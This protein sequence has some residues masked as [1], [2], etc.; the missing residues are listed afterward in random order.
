[1]SGRLAAALIL[2]LALVLFT[3]CGE[4]EQTTIRHERFNEEPSQPEPI[5][6]S[7][8]SLSG[9]YVITSITDEYAPANRTSGPQ[10]TI[11][12]DAAGQFVREVTSGGTVRRRETGSYVIGSRGE[13]ALY[14]EQTGSELLQTARV[15]RYRLIEQSD[16][17]LVLERGPGNQIVLERK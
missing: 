11:S 3:S 12:F 1:M 6:N 5:E 2:S 13:F 14:I 7:G 15:E 17:K 10:T 9:S 16:R 4:K 8:K